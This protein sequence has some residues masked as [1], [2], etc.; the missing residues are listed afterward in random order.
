M[1]V[2]SRSIAALRVFGDDLD[3]REV[4]RLLAAT[5]SDS[6]RKGEVHVSSAGRRYVRKTGMWC[7]EARGEAPDSLQSQISRILSVLTS[8]LEAWR[9]LAQRFEIDMFC[10]LFM[11]ESSEGLDMSS[12][13]MELMA[14]RRI[15]LAICIYGPDDPQLEPGGPCPCRSGSSYGDCCA[16]RRVAEQIA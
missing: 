8:D 3:P 9:T 10:G 11:T 15:P 13:V 7:L 14:E 4:S 12:A 2:K 6:H 1:T 5:P 16:I